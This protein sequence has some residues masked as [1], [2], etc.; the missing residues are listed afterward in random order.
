MLDELLVREKAHTREGDAIAAARRRL[1]MVEVDPAIPLTA[2]HGPVPLLDVFEG[3]RPLIACFRMW[4]DGKPAAAQCEGCT[5]F[6]G[7]AGEL[8]C[9]HSRDVT[10][11]TFCQGP[12]AESAACRD[13]MGWEFSWYP[14]GD[15]AGALV[16]GRWFGMHV[17]CLRDGDRVFE[18]Y[19]D[20]GRAT[21]MAAPA[22]GLPD[23][24][25]YGRQEWREDSPG[26]WPKPFGPCGDAF[27]LKG[28]PAA[29]R[30][31]LAAG[32]SD[33]LGNGNRA[34]RSSPTAALSSCA[35]SPSSGCP[36]GTASTCCPS[37]RAR[38][39]RCSQLTRIRGACALRR[40]RPIPEASSNSSTCPCR[41]VPPRSG[42]SRSARPCSPSAAP[43][44]AARESSPCGLITRISMT[45]V[46][47]F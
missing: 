40:A 27:R 19:R 21:E 5:F 39:F 20:T 36:T 32:R 10:Y 17:Y 13:F 2:E 28:R 44:S 14:V 37:R 29:Q 35:L 16:A 22:C 25:V 3:R 33:D 42:R 6:N 8:S 45:A 30:E 15:S 41:P 23:R 4:H 46:A 26:G 47:Y 11:A 9:L 38:A 34:T 12:Y 18:T 31:R 7:Q 43:R 24:T 1:P